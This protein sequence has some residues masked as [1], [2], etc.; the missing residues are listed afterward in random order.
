[1]KTSF[2]MYLSFYEPVKHFSNDNLGELFRAIFNYH[3]TGGEPSTDSP[4]FVA[5]QFMKSQFENDNLKYL[6]TCDKNKANAKK[7]WDAVASKRI[8]SNAKHTDND[9]DVDNEVGYDNI[10][11]SKLIECFNDIFSKRSKVISDAVKKK[12]NARLKE[13]YSKADIVNAM[14]AASKDDYHKETNFKYCTLEFFSRSDKLDRF[15]NQKEV[16]QKYIGTL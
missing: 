12:Y 6:E 1:M 16:K 5:F 4:I 11:W 9:N 13:G 14:K 8:T 7:R 3:S 2:I 15:I 10:K